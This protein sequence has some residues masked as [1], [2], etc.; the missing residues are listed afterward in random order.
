MMACATGR[1]RQPRAPYPWAPSGALWFAAGIPKPRLATDRR[2]ENSY[3]SDNKEDLYVV[4]RLVLV[5]ALAAFQ[6]REAGY[7]L[8]ASHTVRRR[9]RG[10]QSADTRAGSEVLE[11][12]GLD[13]R[14]QFRVVIL[15]FDM[16]QLDRR[17]NLSLCSMSG[18]TRKRSLGLPELIEDPGHP[19]PTA[20]A[21]VE[22]PAGS[23]AR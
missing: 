17:T 8:R 22:D 21:S 7:G 19:D 16:L 6:I 5:S 18:A 11:V 2:N 1:V 4:K 23:T 13:R 15:R 12:D 10:S 14:G 20:N 9:L 3:S